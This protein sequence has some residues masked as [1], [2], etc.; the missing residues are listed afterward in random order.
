MTF[1]YWARYGFLLL[2]IL[3]VAC[4]FLVHLMTQKAGSGR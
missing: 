3:V 2:L 4:L 1:L